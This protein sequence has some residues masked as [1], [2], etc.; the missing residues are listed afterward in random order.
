VEAHRFVR[1]VGIIVVP[2]PAGALVCEAS[3]KACIPITP[4]DVHFARAG[5]AL[6]A[7]HAHDSAGDHAEIFFE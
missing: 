6:V 3:C 1:I 5:E 7:H 4:R 2:N